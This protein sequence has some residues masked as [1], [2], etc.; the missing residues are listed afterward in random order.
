MDNDD[1]VPS[2]VMTV[3]QLRAI[4]SAPR[5]FR[6]ILDSEGNITNYWVKLDARD[7]MSIDR[8]T[9]M[10]ESEIRWDFHGAVRSDFLRGRDVWFIRFGAW[11][12]RMDGPMP[13]PKLFGYY[14]KKY[15][16]VLGCSGETVREITS[17]Q[18]EN[19]TGCKFEAGYRWWK[20]EGHAD[21]QEVM[22]QYLNMSSKR[23][24]L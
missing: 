6:V 8:V 5:T 14:H 19:A 2:H 9:F 7:A 3:E 13:H 15:H 17:T 20:L 16:G 21:A 11:K 23:R 1:W 24:Y 4:Q 12:A 18:I 22:Q 10:R